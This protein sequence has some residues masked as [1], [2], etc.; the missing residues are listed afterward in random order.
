MSK[1]TF[2]HAFRG[3]EDLIEAI[4]EGIRVEIQSR[5]K[6]LIDADTPFTE[7]LH[8]VMTTIADQICKIGR[9][10]AEDMQRVF[11]HFW[12]RIQEFR[13][14]T[15]NTTLIRLI[16]Q[17]VREGAIRRDVNL[18]IFLLAYIGAIDAVA[19]PDVLANESFSM[20]DAVG[21]I[22]A[23]F[24]HGVLTE[25]ASKELHQLQHNNRSHTS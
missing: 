18:R 23:I 21:N 6:K 12:Q 7:K 5:M 13:R 2:Y 11:P 10:F 4:I 1:K 25:E 22:M 17:G 14:I 24:F 15:M 19:R 3:K 9:P 20:A 8:G 16:E